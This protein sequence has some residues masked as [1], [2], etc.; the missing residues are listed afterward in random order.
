MMDSRDDERRPTTNPTIHRER[1][2]VSH[3]HDEQDGS[4]IITADE[5]QQLFKA[6]SKSSKTP[7][8][9]SGKSGK[10]SGGKS[11]TGAK[12]SKAS[13]LGKSK[14]SKKM[15]ESKTGKTIIRD[16]K[17]AKEDSVGPAKLLPTDASDLVPINSAPTPLPTFSKSAV[18]SGGTS[19][20]SVPID[21][22]TPLGTTSDS[23]GE[24]NSKIPPLNTAMG[25]PT[26]QPPVTSEATVQSKSP[27]I[28]T[29]QAPAMIVP[30]NIRPEME[31]VAKA[32]D[33]TANEPSSMSQDA[34]TSEVED[35]ST[36]FGEGGGSFDPP[37][38]GV[39]SGTDD[40]LGEGDSSFGPPFGGVTAG[41]DD[42]LGEEGNSSDP[43]FDGVP[44]GTDDM[45]GKGGNSSFG[46]PFDIVPAGGT[47]DTDEAAV[48]PRLNQTLPVSDGVERVAP[49]VTTDPSTEGTSGGLPIGAYVGIAVGAIVVAITILLVRRMLNRPRGRYDPVVVDSEQQRDPS[50]YEDDDDSETE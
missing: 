1:T 42:I 40:I 11:V 30:V 27:T 33:D 10:K 39:L 20:A 37:F 50:I 15:I 32:P 28:S 34:I 13:L 22:P 4:S 6:N 31:P 19:D 25:A 26:P 16:P 38:G 2:R 47:D 29:A 23:A 48:P 8:N 44:A 49:P 3:A 9:K 43:P 17:A 46:P 7:R 21:A 14:S 18:Q 24:G 45:L 5:Q 36:P 12:S 41:T 35:G